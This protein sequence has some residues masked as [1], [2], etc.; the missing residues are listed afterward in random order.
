M[1]ATA[2]S[3]G[4]F[5]PI[6]FFVTLNELTIHQHR[7]LR[8]LAGV[9]REANK[10]TPKNSAELVFS[11]LKYLKVPNSFISISLILPHIAKPSAIRPF[12]L[13]AAR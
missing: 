10:T 2:V 4:F 8:H 5:F 13:L 3:S 6:R 7:F 11:Q 12:S 9:Q 1:T